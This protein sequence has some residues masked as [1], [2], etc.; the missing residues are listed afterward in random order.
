MDGSFFDNYSR[1]GKKFKEDSYRMRNVRD[2]FLSSRNQ[3]S[4]NEAISAPILRDLT[5]E[6]TPPAASRN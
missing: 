1:A 3:A 2:Q 4:V 5:T 6:F